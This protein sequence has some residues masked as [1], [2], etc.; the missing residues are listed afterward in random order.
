MRLA[1]WIEDVHVQRIF[2]KHENLHSAILV[3]TFEKQQVTLAFTYAHDEEDGSR[4][5]LEEWEK[6]TIQSLQDEF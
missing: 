5:N 3:G 1:I 4:I 6:E 2:D